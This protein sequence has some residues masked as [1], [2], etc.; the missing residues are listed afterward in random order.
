MLALGL[1]LALRPSDSVQLGGLSLLDLVVF[2]LVAGEELGWRGYALPALLKRR[3]PLQASLVLGVLWGVWHLPTF[4]II[5]T[6]Q[7]GRPFA[8]FL[9]MTTAYSV[10]LS[11]AWLGTRGSVLIATVFHG[12]INLSQGFFLGGV[13]PATQYWLLAG[14]Y[15]LAALVLVLRL[16]PTMRRTS[17][18]SQESSQDTRSTTRV[19]E[20]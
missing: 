16:G 14:V 10:L 11:W 5:G 13:D 20:V 6:P 1:H 12:S 18:T 15:V 17:E 7:Y 3:S 4:L 19:E 9:L 8:A 2:V